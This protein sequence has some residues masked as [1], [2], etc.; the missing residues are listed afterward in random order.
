MTAP[1]GRTEGA[2]AALSAIRIA[3]RR[4]MHTP[5]LAGVAGV[6]VGKTSVEDA[7]RLTAD[8]VAAEE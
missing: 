3:A 5:V 7:V 6:L 2:R 4:G 8:S 1:G